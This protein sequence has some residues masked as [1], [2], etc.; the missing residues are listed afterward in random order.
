METETHKNTQ[1]NTNLG[2]DIRNRSFSYSSTQ[3][4]SITVLPF[5][6]RFFFSEKFFKITNQIEI[7]TFQN[8]NLSVSIC[9]LI[10]FNISLSLYQSVPFSSSISL[11]ICRFDSLSKT[12]RLKT[13][14]SCC[15]AVLLKKGLYIIKKIIFYYYYYYFCFKFYAL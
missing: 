13:Y 7:F 10:L 8:R 11:Y 1:I 2:V 15:F 9:T 6:L 12:S 4:H 3:V 5:F 14:A